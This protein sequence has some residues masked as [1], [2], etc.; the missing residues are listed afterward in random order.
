MS[1]EWKK[2]NEKPIKVGYRKLIRKHFRLP[3]G[4]E[5]DFDI[6]DEC[7]VVCILPIT[8]DGKVILAKQF[9]PGPEKVLMEL[10]GGGMETNE[11]PLESAAREL[12]GETGYQGKTKLV[13]TSLDCGYSNRI[14]YNFVATECKKVAEVK[15][16]PNEPIEVV[17]I[18]REEFRELLRSGEITDIETG[19]LGLD[20]LGLL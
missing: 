7:K 18:S 11:T 14:R 20:Y 4:V 2:L 6:K 3:S 12:L 16:D 19:Y 9:R 15:D 10:P 5:N 8:H 13:G 17:L 1:L